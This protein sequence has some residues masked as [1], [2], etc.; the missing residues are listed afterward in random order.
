MNISEYAF[1]FNANCSI[2]ITTDSMCEP[3]SN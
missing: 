1:V 3:V 2:V